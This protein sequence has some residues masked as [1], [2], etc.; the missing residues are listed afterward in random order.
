MLDYIY[1]FY[2]LG[3]FLRVCPRVPQ[4]PQRGFCPGLRPRFLVPLSDCLTNALE[5][6]LFFGASFSGSAVSIPTEAKSRLSARSSKTPKS[7]S[8]LSKKLFNPPCIFSLSLSYSP[9]ILNLIGA[10]KN[11]FTFFL[12]LSRF[13]RQRWSNC[14]THQPASQPASSAALHPEA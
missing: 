2:N 14:Q 1:F 6:L 11:F 4:L 9:I 7:S 3:H 10:V 12:L 5:S 8:R 13:I